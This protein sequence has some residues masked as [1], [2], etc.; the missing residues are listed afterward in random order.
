MTKKRLFPL[1]IV[2]IVAGIG[3]AR[4]AG[5]RHVPGDF[6][7]YHRAGRMVVTG[8][9]ALL[10]D[11]PFLESQAVYASER[12]PGGDP[13]V[14][15]EFKY[16]PGLAVLLAPLG[17]LP[18]H[19]ANVIWCACNAALVA[20]LFLVSWRWCARGSSAWWMLVPL[21]VL[22]RPVLDNVNLGQV[23]PSAIVPATVGVWWLARRRALASGAA[24]GFGAAVK[25]MP[26]VLALWFAAKWRWQALAASALTV[27]VLWAALPALVLGPS[28]AIELNQ[29]W[30]DAR[31]HHFTSADAEHLPGYSV[32]SFVY[33]VLGTTP[34]PSRRH[35]TVT[36]GAGVLSPEA[37]SAL[38]LLLD[39][40]LLAAALWICRGPLCEADDPRGALEAGLLLTALPLVSPEARFPHF[41][42]L[43]LP[44]TA[45]TYTLV[46]DRGSSRARRAALLLTLAGALLVNATSGRLLGARL[47]LLAEVY[48]VPGWGAL[49]FFTALALLVSEDRVATSATGTASHPGWASAGAAAGR[50][51]D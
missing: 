45:L 26:G 17:A 44:L 37:L 5:M 28:R 16:A 42:F 2:L 24:I 43:A 20:V 48:C 33:R 6:L 31:A 10:Y 25:F 4:G 50:H 46:R 41:L 15:R 36:V 12:E 38:T 49:L 34:Y 18:P 21:V 32:K 3:A 35:E 8:Q 13:L 47:G 7:R 1:L 14:E 40:L 11:A 9:A 22:L 51:P 29:A 27:V 30:L 39:G 23:N 19:A